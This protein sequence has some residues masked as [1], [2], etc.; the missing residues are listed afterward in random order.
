MAAA[1]QGTCLEEEFLCTIRGMN[2]RDASTRFLERFGDEYDY[3]E[4]RRKKTEYFARLREE[5]GLPVKPGLYELL[6]YLKEHDYKIALATAS[7]LEYSEKNLKESGVAD[8]FRYIVT[9]DTVEHA[10]P[11]PEIFLNTARVLEEAPENCLVLEDS[12]NGVEAGI[13][14]GFI[15]VMVPDLTWPDEALS[16]RLSRVCESLLDVKEWME[17]EI[18]T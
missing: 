17:K 4:M 11:D 13:K 9:G 15:T 12:L 2:Y 10:K 18:T 6:A 3:S 14:G 7:S 8:Y 16:A 5:R 1:E